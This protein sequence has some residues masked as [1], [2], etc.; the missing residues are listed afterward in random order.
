MSSQLLPSAPLSI[1]PPPPS[2]ARP[3]LLLHTL[4][5]RTHIPPHVYKHP[6][7]I[8]LEL[9]TSMAEL[10]QILPL[11][12]K[13][14]LYDEH[15][16]QTKLV[17]LFCKFGSMPEAARVFDP[18]DDKIDPLYHTMLKG[19]GKQ[20][21]GYVVRAGFELLVNVSTALVDMYCKCGLVGTARLI[22][23]R[24][25]NRTV[26]SWNSMID[27]YA[28][29]GDSKEAWILFKKMLDEGLKPTG[30]TI[31]AAL[32]ACADSGDLAGGEFVH[33]LVNQLGFVS[34]ISVMNS[35]I[36]MYSKCK[37]VD[38]AAKL[39]EDLP[40]RT[41]VSWNAMILGYA[42]NGHITEALNHFCSVG[43]KSLLA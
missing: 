38:I 30:V 10:R 9:C 2:K 4:S 1:T 24:M 8:L 32:H 25:R 23:D 31:M 40:F 22:F 15:L 6:S 16:F 35:L 27:G 18:I 42:Q 39:F 12:V 5:Q 34:D 29:S 20:I 28:Q 11:I 26:V 19:S 33:Q 7:A 21:H 3:P 43:G 13:N 41:L 37:R 36:S 17:S 14:G